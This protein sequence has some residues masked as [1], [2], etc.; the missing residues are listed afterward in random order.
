[1]PAHPTAD[2]WGP[3]LSILVLAALLGCALGA[4]LQVAL[5]AV[6]QMSFLPFVTTVIVVAWAW[7]FASAMRRT[8]RETLR[9]AAQDQFEDAAEMIEVWD[10]V[11]ARQEAKIGDP[12]Y[13][14]DIGGGKLLVLGGAGLDD[15]PVLRLGRP[16]PSRHEEREDEASRR[17]FLTSHFILHRG[18]RSGRILR[19][20][21]LGEPISICRILPLAAVAK[22]TQPSCV[23]DGS[24]PSLS[25]SLPRP[26]LR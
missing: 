19:V 24:L 3:A 8:R 11:A 14:L 22:G 7:R 21:V 6:I 25:R 20:D 23:V 15:V 12:A 13:V 1:M 26:G 2:E 4:V 18:R 9:R 5:R 10:P 17:P 16:W